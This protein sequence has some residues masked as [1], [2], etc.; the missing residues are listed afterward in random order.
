MVSSVEEQ[1]IKMIDAIKQCVK[2]GYNQ[3]D[4][5][6]LSCHAGGEFGVQ[7][8]YCSVLGK[9]TFNDKF[10]YGGED[11]SKIALYHCLDFRG[12]ES[13]VVV[14]T[15]IQGQESVFRANYLSGSRAKTRLLLIRV[16]DN[17]VRKARE[18][19]I[20]KGLSFN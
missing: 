5:V 7:D 16:E 13:H 9:R 17:D 18:I 1:D 20:P 3:K 10:S 14:V 15:D 12:L 8:K 2:E 19:K 11:K 4:I 6:V